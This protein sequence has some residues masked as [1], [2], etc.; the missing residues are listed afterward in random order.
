ME[1]TLPHIETMKPEGVLD[2]IEDIDRLDRI[3]RRTYGINDGP[4]IGLNL[5]MHRSDG[6]QE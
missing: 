2:R 1:K 5:H 4:V 6:G 3:A